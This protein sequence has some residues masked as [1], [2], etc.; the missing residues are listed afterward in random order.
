MTRPLDGEQRAET[1]L[2]LAV[3]EQKSGKAADV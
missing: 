2:K 3:G 1:E